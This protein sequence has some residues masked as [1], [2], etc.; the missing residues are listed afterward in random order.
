MFIVLQANLF[1]PWVVDISYP[2]ITIEHVTFCRIQIV[3]AHNKLVEPEKT[4]IHTVGDLPSC[5]QVSYEGYT[6]KLLRYAM[7][8]GGP[9]TQPC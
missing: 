3:D 5:Y 4:P 1:L 6:G 8:F 7:I 2:E 9:N